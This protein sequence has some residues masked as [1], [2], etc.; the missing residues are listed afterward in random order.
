[1]AVGNLPIMTLV[2]SQAKTPDQ[3]GGSHLREVPAMNGKIA[4]TLTTA[5][6]LGVILAD[7]EGIARAWARW[8]ADPS[9]VSAFH[10]ATCGLF[11]AED[12]AALG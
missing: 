6:A 2:L 1:M 8:Q 5:A 12:V 4:V 11:L 9:L 3:T 10:L 7:A